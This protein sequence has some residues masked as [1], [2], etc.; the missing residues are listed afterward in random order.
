MNRG[1][2]RKKNYS[3]Y[4]C[5]IHCAMI[6]ISLLYLPIYIMEGSINSHRDTYI[7]FCS[8]LFTANSTLSGLFGLQSTVYSLR[9]TVCGQRSTATASNKF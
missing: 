5:N 1:I 4:V 7:E 2:F 8:P 9:S 6:H 3:F